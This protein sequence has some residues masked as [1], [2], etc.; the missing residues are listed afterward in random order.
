MAQT[1]IHAQESTH[2]STVSPM[3]VDPG[4]SE[5]GES[6]LGE[7]SLQRPRGNGSLIRG[8]LGNTDKAVNEIKF[9]VR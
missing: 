7:L 9:N 5:I 3:N 1:R 2:C 8:H 6:E 4:K